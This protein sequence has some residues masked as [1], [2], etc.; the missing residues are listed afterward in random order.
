MQ[1]TACRLRIVVCGGCGLE[2]E[3]FKLRAHCRF[4]CPKRIVPCGGERTFDIQRK[5][6]EAH[7][8]IGVVP[9][10][11][12][13]GDLLDDRNGDSDDDSVAH[14]PEFGT[15]PGC[16]AMVAFD[17]V[18]DHLANHCINRPLPCVWCGDKYSPP[19][20]RETHELHSCPCRPVPCDLDCGLTMPHRDLDDNKANHCVM[21][22]VPCRRRCGELVKFQD[23]EVH[24]RRGDEGVCAVRPTLCRY[25]V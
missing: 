15:H 23:L 19:L 4:D 2:M 21:R 11:A 7:D 3:A 20:V 10:D 18:P 9:V 25:G 8:K 17:Q 16:D 13:D 6:K 5:R 14:V 1:K 22:L 12:D 24:E